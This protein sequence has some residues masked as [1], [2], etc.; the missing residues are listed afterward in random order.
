MADHIDRS[1]DRD[2]AIAQLDGAGITD[3]LVRTEVGLIIEAWEGIET[4]VDPEAAAEA[5]AIAA[6]LALGHS[7][8][9]PAEETEEVWVDIIPGQVKVA[10]TVRVRAEAFEGKTGQM[11]NGR[12]GRIVA[13]RNG[14]IIVKSTDGKNPILDGVHYSP[15]NL[16]KRVK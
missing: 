3:P 12:V 4:T 7:L 13:I 11:H 5:F 6:K 2:W 9:T 14:N 8:S 15:Y 16:E 10:D 1:V